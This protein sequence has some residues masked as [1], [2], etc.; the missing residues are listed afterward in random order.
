MPNALAS[1]VDTEL[2]MLLA[3]LFEGRRI[4][5]RTG[6]VTEI[7]QAGVGVGDGKC[8]FRPFNRD[9]KRM[10]HFFYFPIV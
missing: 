1:V 9:S 5:A 4:N 3:R 8:Q 10:H 2:K 7:D 6:G